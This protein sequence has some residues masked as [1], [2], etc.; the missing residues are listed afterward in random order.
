LDTPHPPPATRVLESVRKWRAILSPVFGIA[1]LGIFIYWIWNYRGA[2]W[3]TFA[4][5]GP[6]QLVGIIFLLLLSGMLTVFAFVLLVRSKGYD[7][8]FVDGY[9]TLNYSQ[10]ASMIPGGIWGFAGLAGALWSKRISKADSILVIFL[11]TLIMLTACAIVGITGLASTL[12]WEYAI[13]C[14]LPF[15]FLLI[16]RNWLDKIRQRLLPDSSQLPSTIILFK[17]LIIGI[18]VWM[19]ASFCF[20]WL[21][22]SSTGFGVVPFWAAS[23]AYATGYLGG[24]ITLLAPSGLGVSEGLVAL[25]LGPSIGTEKVLAI[26]ISFRIINTFVVWCNILVTVILTSRRPSK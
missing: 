14:L 26:A 22:Y 21:L 5:I 24:Y 2:I 15:V 12:G 1:I 19:I 25:M 10:L 17:V 16:G 20:T 7:F 3:S 18:A 8:K 13:V 9:N 4:Q 11:N 6:A 23:G